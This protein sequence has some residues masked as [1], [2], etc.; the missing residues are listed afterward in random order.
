MVTCRCISKSLHSSNE[1][2]AHLAWKHDLNSC[3]NV[4][5]LL[6]TAGVDRV[7]ASAAAMYGL[8]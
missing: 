5:F 2:L 7:P 1:A 8:P 6:A 3:S 4:A